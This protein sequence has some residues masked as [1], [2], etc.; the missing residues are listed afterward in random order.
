MGD[1]IGGLFGSSGAKDA[2]KATERAAQQAR[3]TELEMYYQ[4]REDIQPWRTVGG[5]ALDQL[6]ALMG[7]PGTGAGMPAGGTQTAMTE[8]EYNKMQQQLI[9]LQTAQ[10]RDKVMRDSSSYGGLSPQTSMALKQNKI[11][12]AV[13]QWKKQQ[14]LLPWEQLTAQERAQYGYYGGQPQSGA[15]QAPQGAQGVPDYSSFYQS[16]DYQFRLQE[17]LKAL[18]RSAAAKGNLQSGSTLKGITEY[19]Q[20]MAGQAY[21]DYYNRLASLANVGQTASQYTGGLGQQAASGASQAL[22]EG[23]ARSSAYTQEAGNMMGS[24]IGT[25]INTGLGFLLSDIT[26]KENVEFIGQENGHNIYSF[27]Y[28]GDD[29]KYKGVIAQEVLETTPDAVSC[30]DDGLL[31]VDYSKLGLKMEVLQCH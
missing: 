16:P 24:G 27:N 22:T 28:K 7:L 1:I 17:G 18:E 13:E 25:A 14:G 2:A 6:S 21:G 4:S 8:P 31:R 5:Q 15:G 3:D 30:G 10:I 29:V 12:D 26:A 9:D 23:A 20:G 19:G 11:D